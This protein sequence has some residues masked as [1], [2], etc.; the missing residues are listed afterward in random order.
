MTQKTYHLIPTSQSI[1]LSYGHSK[2]HYK[3]TVQP[4]TL[5]TFPCLQVWAI[6][7]RPKD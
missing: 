6:G 7:V 5:S 3:A 1:P 2:I 4:A